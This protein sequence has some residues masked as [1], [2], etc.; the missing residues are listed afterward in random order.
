MG[1]LIQQ[2]DFRKNEANRRE[3]L[4]GGLEVASSKNIFNVFD[5]LFHDD[6]V[7]LHLR[8]DRLR[9]AFLGDAVNL[10]TTFVS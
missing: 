2:I 9:S 5:E 1:N 7:Q 6:V 4:F 3:W 10:L 8:N